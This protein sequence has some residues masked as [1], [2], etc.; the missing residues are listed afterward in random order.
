MRDRSISLELIDHGRKFRLSHLSRLEIT[1][2][3]LALRHATLLREMHWVKNESTKPFELLDRFDE[4]AHAFGVYL[5]NELIA[6]A[7]LIPGASTR[8]VPS[9]PF[10]PASRNYDGGLAEVSKVMVQPRFRNYGLFTSLLVR[11]QIEAVISTI[12]HLFITVVNS[13]RIREFLGTHGFSVVGA[14]F[15]YEDA[16]IAP[17]SATI[18]MY[19]ELPNMAGPEMQDLDASLRSVFERASHELLQRVP[20]PKQ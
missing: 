3:Y 11:C 14:P 19:A 10:V 6:A 5:D 18:L 8:D 15:R 1:G 4:F 16:T 13:T 12:R 17:H 2:D 7:R 20:L 9:G